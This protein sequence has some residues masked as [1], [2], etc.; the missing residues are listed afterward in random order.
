MCATVRAFVLGAHLN[1]DL[2]SPDEQTCLEHLTASK[3]P[4]RGISLDVF[5]LPVGLEN[6]HLQKAISKRVYKYDV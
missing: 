4:K 5:I 3:R 1:F 2:N 6:V